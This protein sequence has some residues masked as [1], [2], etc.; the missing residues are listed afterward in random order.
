MNLLLAAALLSVAVAQEPAQMVVVDVDLL[1]RPEQA[2][3]SLLWLGVTAAQTDGSW[4]IPGAAPRVLE[5]S[6]PMALSDHWS[7][8]LPMVPGLRYFAVIDTN[9]SGN[10]DKGEPIGGPIDLSAA[11][12]AGRAA[13]TVD[14][15]LGLG[16]GSRRSI[17]ATVPIEGPEERRRSDLSTRAP[18]PRGQGTPT[19]VSLTVG[20]E[21]AFFDEGRFVAVGF[22][23]G[24]P[25]TGGFLPEDATFV[26]TS[27]RLALRW[28]M[29]LDA[30]LPSG[31][32]VVF[33]LDLDGDGDLGPGDLIARPL[34]AFDPGAEAEFHLDRTLPQVRAAAPSAHPDHRPR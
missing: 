18:E 15:R 1:V 27:E 4:L 26:W 33:G 11:A 6:A 7:L 22:E 23:P 32:D 19:P 2:E 21:L 5:A 16:D 31:L 10:P 30:V 25:W 14:H 9:G 3:A 34:P 24:T 8:V 28:P 17:R 29:T 20:P 13:I 12:G